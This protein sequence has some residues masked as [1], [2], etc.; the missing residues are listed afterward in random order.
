MN[1]ISER[2]HEITYRGA[3]GFII[4]DNGDDGDR[5]QDN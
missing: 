1:Q 2:T 4:V 5:K 3:N